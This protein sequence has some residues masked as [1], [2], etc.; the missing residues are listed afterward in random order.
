MEKGFSQTDLAKKIGVSSAFV[1][2]VENGRGQWPNERI[3]H[4]CK[5][6]G[7][8]REVMIHTITKDFEARL[9]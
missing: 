5:V 9:R 3:S 2:K 7:L 4:L 1:N 6:L 8:K